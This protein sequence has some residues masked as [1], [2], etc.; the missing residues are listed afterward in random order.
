MSCVHVINAFPCVLFPTII[1]AD[2]IDYILGLTSKIV[3]NLIRQASEI[4]FESVSFF[5]SGT[6]GTFSA[7]PTMVMLETPCRLVIKIT[8]VLM[9]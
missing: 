4:A 8:T 7:S 2:K 5:N 9:R 6:K 1:T 3:S